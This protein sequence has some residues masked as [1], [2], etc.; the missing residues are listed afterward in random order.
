[1]YG[2]VEVEAVTH[3]FN[4]DNGFVSVV[5]PDLCLEV[6]DYYTVTSFDVTAGACQM[7][8]AD[9][10]LAVA[11]LAAGPGAPVVYGAVTA[12]KGIGFLAAWAGVKLAMWSQDGAPVLAT[13]LSFGGKPFISMSLGP[14]KTSLILGLF[15]KWHQYWDDLGDAWHKFD[16]SEEIFE[17][18]INMTEGI[19]NIYGTTAEGQGNDNNRLTGD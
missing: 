7:A 9:P 10:Y 3:I 19:Y 12:L 6:N 16:L 8:W 18:R 15:G 4:R 17:Q 14:N 11:S 1:M 13:P 5:T 2:P